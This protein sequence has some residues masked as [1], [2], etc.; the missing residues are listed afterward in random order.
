MLA[1]HAMSRCRHLDLPLPPLSSVVQV[2]PY[3]YRLDK[4]IFPPLCSFY[5]LRRKAIFACRFL[6]KTYV[7]FSVAGEGEVAVLQASFRERVL[8]TD[9]GKLVPLKQFPR[10]RYKDLAPKPRTP[11]YILL[12]VF[13]IALAHLNKKI[14]K[15]TK[16]LLVWGFSLAVLEVSQ[17]E[18]GISTSHLLSGFLLG[19]SYR[20]HS[21][22]SFGYPRE[23][24]A[25]MPNKGNNT[26]VS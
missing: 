18:L 22:L 2:E 11:Y 1:A 3:L 24:L 26:S 17:P 8:Q 12:V 20:R 23:P 7:R 5:Q 21:M 25:F 10:G 15:I 9:L 4:M 6:M 19:Y 14:D 16:S 13:C